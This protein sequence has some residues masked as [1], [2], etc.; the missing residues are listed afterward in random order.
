MNKKTF[1]FLA[2]F[3]IFA[4]VA[5]A[6][7]GSVLSITNNTPYTTGGATGSIQC[8][9]STTADGQIATQWKYRLKSN[10]PTDWNTL[11]PHNMGELVGLLFTGPSYAYYE[12]MFVPPNGIGFTSTNPVL[13]KVNSRKTTIVTIHYQ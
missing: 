2:A 10:T 13:V 1:S 12:V 9:N 7:N 4:V 3:L 11:A 6:Q 8:L 5:H